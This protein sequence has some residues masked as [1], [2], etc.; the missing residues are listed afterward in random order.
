MRITK[1]SRI[2]T[3][4]INN[5]FVK[6]RDVLFVC[7]RSKQN[8]KYIFGPVPSRRFG[9]SLGIDIIPRKKCTLDCIYCQLGKT[10]GLTIRRKPYAAVKPVLEELKK[11]LRTKTKIDCLTFSG[12]GE[13]TLNSNIGK[14]ISGIKKI[15]KIPVV[16]I[17]NG[18][19][20]YREYVRCDLMKADIVAPSLDAI[21][22]FKKIN[23]PNKE[24]DIKK[25]IGGLIKF[26]KIY[27]GKIWLEILF[28]KNINDSS[29]EITELKKAVRK[30]KPDKI[31][32][33]TVL[34]PPAESRAKPLNYSEL[35]KIKK[36]LGKTAEIISDEKHVKPDTKEKK[37]SKKILDILRRRPMRFEDIK[38]VIQT[39]NKTI[40]KELWLL[41]RKK[42]ISFQNNWWSRKFYN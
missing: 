28:A 31:H 11:I 8:M 32:L 40:L 1:T 26:R 42:K 27:P 4:N 7:L 25:I 3:N 39:D 5:I 23:R 41:E 19:L 22:S 35:L 24:L 30:I 12:S 17:T 2:V 37:I 33:N 9:K 38:S 18:T 34:R 10:T 21:L 29:A 36:M 14:M 6:I 15:T 13:P 16:V 20:L